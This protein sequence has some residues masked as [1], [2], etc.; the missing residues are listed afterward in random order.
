MIRKEPVSLSLLIVLLLC[1]LWGSLQAADWQG[2]TVNVDIQTPHPYP[3]GTAEKP[4]VWEYTIEHPGATWIMVHFSDF[5][6]RSPLGWDSFENDYVTILDK[7]RVPVAVYTGRG[8]R[9][10]GEF[11]ALEVQ[12]DVAII[13]LRSDGKGTGHGFTIDKY[14][15][16]F[17][18]MAIFHCGANT[19]EDMTKYHAAGPTPNAALWRAGEAVARLLLFDQQ[20]DSLGWCTGFCIDL[21][22]NNWNL[23]MTNEH[24]LEGVGSITAQ[25]KYEY[26]APFGTFH[27][28]PTIPDPYNSIHFCAPDSTHD[29]GLVWLEDSPCSEGLYGTLSPAGRAPVEGEDIVVIQHPSHRPKELDFNVT[30]VNVPECDFL[31]RCDIESGSSG[32]PVIA[33]SSPYKSVIGVVWGGAC[34]GAIPETGWNIAV[35]MSWIEAYIDSVGIPTKVQLSSFTAEGSGL[36][37]KLRWSTATEIDNTGFNVYRSN[38]RQA[39]K[40]KLNPEIITSRGSELEAATY[41]FVDTG[42]TPGVV[43]YYWLEDVDLGGNRTMHGPV[44]VAA[45][46]AFRLAQNSPNPFKSSTEIEYGLSVGTHVDLTIFDVTGRKVKT[47]VNEHQVAGNKYATW[48]GRDSAGNEV[49]GGVYFYRLRAGGFD[50]MMKMVLIR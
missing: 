30:G 32:S 15:Y 9:D 37:V 34:T 44:S 20:G 26:T 5:D 35:K 41:V 18:P 36:T 1:V 42:I 13:E 14:G 11:W 49:S 25:F 47:L 40:H 24:C 48:D 45:A 8:V 46:T 23:L 50:R 17:E 22:G 29:W 6:V 43:Y 7:D 27:L 12:G 31:H 3:L 38:T 33:D 4:T 16:G 10:R 2:K 19:L 28:P 39:G 21:V